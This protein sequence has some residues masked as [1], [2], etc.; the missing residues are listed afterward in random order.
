MDTNTRTREIVKQWYENL[1]QGN[2]QAAIDSFTDDAEW[3]IPATEYNQI[4]PWVGKLIGREQITEAFRLRDEA[5]VIKAFELKDLLVENNRAIAFVY[6]HSVCKRTQKSFK[7]DIVQRFTLRD[8]KIAGWKAFYDPCSIISAFS[9]N[10]DAQLIDA[11]KDEDLEVVKK[12]LEQGASPNTKEDDVVGLSV[13]MMAACQAN[14]EIVQLLLDAGADVFTADKKSGATALHKACQGGDLKVAEM[15]LNAGAF[16]DAVTP[17]MGHTPIM[18]A[19]WYRWPDIV[20]LLVERGAN[21]HLS[22]HYGFTI[23]DHLSFQLQVNQG[24][25]KQKIVVIKEIIDA[26]RASAQKEI[27]SQTVMAATVDGNKDNVK[28]LINNGADVNT[29][30]P[31]VDSFQD[32]YTP[33]LAAARDGF[34]EIV[35][36]LLATGAEVRVEDWIFKGAPIHKA[37]YNGNPEILQILVDHPDINL[38]VQ[39]PINGYTPLHDALWHGYS[40][41]AKILVAAGADL[42]IKGHDGKTPLMIAID[43][44]GQKSEVVELMHSKLNN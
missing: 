21:L 40:E 34:S 10:L 41:C 13:L 42:T 1:T 17:T 36:T 31:H 6:E 28:K 24:E 18:D 22:T 43:V 15:L 25:E 5:T 7:V 9:S 26:G 27:E 16:V 23:D 44:L 4:V 11:I 30:Y 14:P 3:D 39:G 8:G 33:L 38:D 2:I 19:L 29:V 12:I 35:K 20:R 32:G 37:T